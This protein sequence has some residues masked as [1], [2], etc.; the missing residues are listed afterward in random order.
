ML[1]ASGLKDSFWHE[2]LLLRTM[3]A[4]EAFEG[5]QSIYRFKF[6]KGSSRLEG[7]DQTSEKWL[8]L[9]YQNKFICVEQLYK[10][11]LLFVFVKFAV[12]YR[13]SVAYHHV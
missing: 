8:L 2:L 3:F 10:W 1:R 12:L 11:S 7:G 5:Y 9:S 4:K 6:E 13:R